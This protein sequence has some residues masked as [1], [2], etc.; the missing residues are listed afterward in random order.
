MGEGKW[1]GNDPEPAC[2]QVCKQ[3]CV[4]QIDGFLQTDVWTGDSLGMIRMIGALVGF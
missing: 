2:E 4:G 1:E 3:I